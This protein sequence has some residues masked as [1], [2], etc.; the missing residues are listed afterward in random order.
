MNIDTF[1]IASNPEAEAIA[2]FV[3]KAYRPELG[4]SGWTHE[5]HLLSGNRINK[6]ELLEKRSNLTVKR[7]VS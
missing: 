1:H 4:A 2:A 7:D 6:I 5:A 3:N